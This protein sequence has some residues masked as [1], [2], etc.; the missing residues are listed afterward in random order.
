[1]TSDPAYLDYIDPDF[2]RYCEDEE[3]DEPTNGRG[4]AAAATTSVHPPQSTVILTDQPLTAEEAQRKDTLYRF[5]RPDHWIAYSRTLTVLSHRHSTAKQHRRLAMCG[6]H[7]TIWHSPST[8]RIRVQAY[9]CGLRCCPRCRETHASRT[10]TTLG[11]F[12]ALVPRN[13]LSMITLTTGHDSRPLCEQIDSLYDSFRRLRSSKI[14]KTNKPKGFAVLEITRNTD[15]NEWHPHLHL[16]AETPYMPHA[17]LK[18]AWTTATRGS[19]SIVDIRRVNRQSVERYQHYLTDY[20]TKPATT[21]ILNHTALLTEWIDG[22]S[23]RKVLIRFGRPKLAD[24]PEKPTDPKDWSLI[25]S[26]I[27]LLAGLARGN[28][29]ATYWLARLGQTNVQESRD[30]DAGKDYSLYPEHRSPNEQFF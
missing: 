19:A 8:D 9:H 3:P 18:N 20:L 27:G 26:L 21:E 22:L 7:A 14:W 4:V 13:R 24:E 28:T 23:H 16:L 5:R 2:L 11:R 12:L 30:I 25:G 1:M 17:T 15:R 6:A 10:R 29:R